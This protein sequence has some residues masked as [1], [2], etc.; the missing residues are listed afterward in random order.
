LEALEPFEKH[1]NHVAPRHGAHDA[2]HDQSSRP[3]AACFP[4][5]FRVRDA[6]IFLSLKPGVRCF[7]K[8]AYGGS[9]RR[10]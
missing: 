9:R 3:G 10:I 8:P 4:M 1:G 7:P 2:A 5:R 6:F